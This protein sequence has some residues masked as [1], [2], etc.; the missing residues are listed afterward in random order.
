MHSWKKKR[1]PYRVGTPPKE[2]A[3]Q[4]PYRVGTL[5]TRE[6]YRVGKPQKRK[7]SRFHLHHADR[8]HLV[9]CGTSWVT[10]SLC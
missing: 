10:R 4:E 3:E 1:E 5:H 6:P 9:N 2:D 8:V 7:G